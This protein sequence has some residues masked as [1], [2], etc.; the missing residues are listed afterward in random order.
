MKGVKLLDHTEEKAREAMA[1]L[2]KIIDRAGEVRARVA[3]LPQA[4]NKMGFEEA[5]IGELVET[6]ISIYRWK[7]TRKI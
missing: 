4:L 2:F 3:L 7:M 1:V 5:E 6:L